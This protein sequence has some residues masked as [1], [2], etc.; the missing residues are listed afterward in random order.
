MAGYVRQL[1]DDEGNKVYP[2]S[3]ASSSYMS[4][5]IVSVETVL[6]DM[7]EGGSKTEFMED[8]RI[9]KTLPSGNKV[10]TEF[11]ANGSIK[12]TTKDSKGNLLITKTTK[13]ESDGSI[14]TSIVYEGEEKEES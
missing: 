7:Q 8:G 6:R 2:V 4:G 11:M 5:G 3:K 14:T 1:I 12:E 9:V 13:F 10:T